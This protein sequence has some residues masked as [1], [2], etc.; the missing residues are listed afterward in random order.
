MSL[1]YTKSK[2]AALIAYPLCALTLA[3]YACRGQ[4]FESRDGHGL[5]IFGR[6]RLWA[7]LV[8]GIA[9]VAAMWLIGVVLAVAVGPLVTGAMATI[10]G[11]VLIGGLICLGSGMS[12]N[13]TGA[14]TPKGHRWQLAALAQRPDTRLSAL[15]LSR[16]LVESAPPGVVIIAEAADDRLLSAYERLGFIRGRK[17]RVYKLADETLA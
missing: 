7:E 10:I 5:V 17:R 3:A 11:T 4:L 14:E 1:A 16:S 13:P 6:Y 9:M 15:Q 2:P 12:A 8:T